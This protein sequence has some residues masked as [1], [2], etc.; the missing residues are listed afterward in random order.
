MELCA[1]G[2]EDNF[3]RTTVRC[4]PLCEFT[5]V[6]EAPESNIACVMASSM[7]LASSCSAALSAFRCS[8]R[9]AQRSADFDVGCGPELA[10]EEDR[11]WL[12]G[13]SSPV[14]AR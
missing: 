4:I 3:V 2:S 11:D 8:S 10:I 6:F 7:V 5:K 12:G 14:A 9:R 13:E 1:T